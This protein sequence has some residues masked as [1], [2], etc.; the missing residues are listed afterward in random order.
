[1]ILPAYDAPPVVETVHG[2]QFNPIPEFNEAYAGWFWKKHLPAEW[3]KSAIVPRLEDQFERFGDQKIWGPELLF[4]IRPSTGGERTQLIHRDDERMIQIQST[5]F[6]YNWKKGG[7][8][9]PYPSYEKL[10]PEFKKSL[11]AFEQFAQQMG[12]KL[13]FNQW[14]VTYVNHIP[15]GKL[16]ASPHDWPSIFPRFST[17]ANDVKGQQ[18]DGFRGEW[19]LSIDDNVGRLHIDL[20]HARHTATNQELLALQLTARGPVTETMSLEAGLN[21]GHESIVRSFDAMISPDARKHWKKTR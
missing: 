17:L 8:S 19:S 16:W 7:P 1:M 11:G 9:Q 4:M 18:P 3:T 6:L 5:R 12:N 2:A 15:K 13:I 14:E 21:K 10:L 20:K